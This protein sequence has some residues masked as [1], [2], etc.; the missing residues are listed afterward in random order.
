LRGIP[1]TRF[2][3]ANVRSVNFTD[4]VVET[5]HVSVPYD[6]LIVA[7]GSTSFFFNIPG[8]AEHSFLLKTLDQAVAL[9]N[10]ILSRLEHAS[11]ESDESR[12]RQ[13][14]TF[15]V[16]GGGATGVEYAGAL[17]ELLHGPAGRD[18]P[19][20]NL[21]DARIILLE[22]MEHLLPEFPLR[23]QEYCQ[24]RL[25]RMGVEVRVRSAV[26]SVTT[27]SVQIKGGE[28]I[29]TDTVIWTAGVRGAA[30]QLP[31]VSLTRQGRVNVLPTLQLPD[32]PQVYVVGDLAHWESG[33]GPLPMVAPAAIQQGTAAA[34]NILRQ[35]KGEEPAAFAYHDK[36]RMATI[37]RNA[38]AVHVAGR[39]FTGFIAWL[40]WLVIH[41]MNLMGFRNRLIVLLNWV[42]DYL[43]M[44]RAIRLIIPSEAPPPTPKP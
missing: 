19:S 27:E 44:E 22:A 21:R 25:E 10:R 9:R 12:R 33:K 14:L 3:M 5:E 36:G 8:A 28:A 41:L 34:K 30:P 13:M 2:V 35:I 23:L 1:N 6:F 42:W 7:T 38:A 15:V 39:S 18:Y 29:A 43:L 26:E 24:K 20:L 11:H 4:Q 16:V 31:D 40:L 17:A 37:G 32:H